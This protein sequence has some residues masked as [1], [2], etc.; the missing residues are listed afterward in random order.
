[1]AKK[2][3]T[4]ELIEAATK[5]ELLDIAGRL[6][7]EEKVHLKMLKAEIHEVVLTEFLAQQ[8][9]TEDAA[10][11]DSGADLDMS[12]DAVV[13]RVH[14]SRKA[15]TQEEPEAAPEPE[16]EPVKPPKFT[17]HILRKGKEGRVSLNELRRVR[18]RLGIKPSTLKQLQNVAVRDGEASKLISKFQ[19]GR[20]VKLSFIVRAR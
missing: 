14:A 17:Y 1:M 13:A 7:V 15:A 19:K 9:G 11:A 6:G 16:P 5:D 18:H 20:I 12:A 3:I 2:K 10:P 4:V 8:E